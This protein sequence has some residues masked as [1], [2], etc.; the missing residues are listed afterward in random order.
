MTNFAFTLQIKSLSATTKSWT[1]HL[2]FQGYLFG[3]SEKAQ[4]RVRTLRFGQRLSCEP[5]ESGHQS[6]VQR[7]QGEVRIMIQF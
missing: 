1:V 2:T 7:F 3:Q 6:T 4:T 5:T